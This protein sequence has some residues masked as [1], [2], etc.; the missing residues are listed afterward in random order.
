MKKKCSVILV[1]LWMLFIFVMSSFNAGVS[2]NQSG[3]IVNFI[4]TLFNIHNVRMLSHIVR[5]SA[6]FIEYFILGL[7]VANM[8]SKF[9]K[10]IYLGIIICF[11]YAVSDELHQLFVLGRSCQIIDILID[12]V[13]ATLA[14]VIFKKHY[15]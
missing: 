12:I 8:F 9:H 1:I 6:H 10:L 7:C 2:S 13:G 4:A 15:K 11:L 5:K 3:K 14:I